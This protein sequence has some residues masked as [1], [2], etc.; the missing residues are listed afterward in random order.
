M[1]SLEYNEIRWH[2]SSYLDSS[3]RLF[4]YKGELYRAISSERA[5]LYR[6]LFDDNTI[7]KLID[8][9]LL[10][11]S[12]VSNLELEEYEIVIK[13]R[14]LPFISYS[15]EWCA[16]M[17][18]DAALLIIDLEV[19]LLKYDLTLHD[20]HS[21]NV[22]F[23]SH[24]PIFVD[25]GS[26]IPVNQNFWQWFSHDEFNWSLIYPLQLMASGFDREARLFLYDIDN[27][28]KR[29]DL[30]AYITKNNWV[31]KRELQLKIS[32][33]LRFGPKINEM[34]NHIISFIN[35]RLS[36]TMLQLKGK[37]FEIPEPVQPKIAT[38]DRKSRMD[39][40]LKLRKL[41]ENIKIS[42]KQERCSNSNS[43]ASFTPSPNW[44]EKD[45]LVYELILA[46]H[47]R[48]LLD[49]GC[50]SGWYSRLAA[51]L[52]SKVVAIDKNESCISQ[53]Y[54]DAKRTTLPVLPLILDFQNPSPGFGVCNKEFPPAGQRLRCD[55]VLF[56]DLIHKVVFN[57]LLKF[58]QI[59]DSCSMFSNEWLLL[60][61]IPSEDMNQ[62]NEY[63]EKFP[64]YSVKNL[65]AVIIRQFPTITAY[66][67]P[68]HRILLLCKK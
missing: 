37:K 6:Q 4:W 5:K 44:S 55:M 35:S 23:D 3:G 12:E 63:S 15:Y 66:T 9:H 16:E 24:R 36:R 49:I 50:K 17:L 67:Y 25:L 11:E 26:I 31:L 51:T 56:L 30:Q 33:S 14:A 32:D 1:V 59:I 18:R 65:M 45:R 38:C 29:T 2:P 8:K 10:I 58:E 22:L 41:A 48:T 53:I 27:G 46:K 61:Y 7:K 40:M 21:R 52:G 60:E 57:D 54:L 42:K 43:P 28:V 20:A 19:E 47:P 13:H 62:R 39:S 34:P 68:D 64:W